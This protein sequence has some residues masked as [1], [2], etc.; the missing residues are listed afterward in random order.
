[1]SW[2]RMTCYR[3]GEE[4]DITVD[5]IE[6]TF[7]LDFEFTCDQMQTGGYWFE[8][9]YTHTKNEELEITKCGFFDDDGDL[10]DIDFMAQ[11]PAWR[12]QVID[13]VTDYAWENLE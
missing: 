9:P 6:R 10:I 7:V 1:M 3:Q 13:A 2:E 11:A 12:Q 8:E 4:L 5:G